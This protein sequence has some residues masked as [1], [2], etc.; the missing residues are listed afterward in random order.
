MN[1]NPL[2]CLCSLLAPI[3]PA[4]AAYT[5]INGNF[6]DTSGTFPAGW[7]TVGTVNNPGSAGFP[8]SAADAFLDPG[9]SI[10]QDFSGGAGTATAENYNFQL[11]FA[12]RTSSIST[13]TNQRIRL[14]DN[15]NT[16][17]LI[18]LGFATTASG[19][20]AALSYYNGGTWTTAVDLGIA[21]GTTYH[22]RVSGFNLDQAGRYYTIGLST[23]GISFTTTA[24]ITAFHDNT[25]GAVG[26]DFES[27]RFESGTSQF[28]ID[29]VSVVPEPS[30]ALLGGLGG[31]GLLAAIR[32]RR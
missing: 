1:K 22:V 11:D 30:A 18:T 19:G 24:N 12:F 32:R 9:E 31:L 20:G 5:L 8:G 17:D 10:T 15:N 16:G 13:A 25:A 29:G 3:A 28:R 6:E 14:R 2:A 27:I 23:D 7:T 21:T 4:H 26:R